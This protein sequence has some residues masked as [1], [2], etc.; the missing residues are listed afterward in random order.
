MGSQ[1]PVQAL[2]ADVALIQI[3]NQPLEQ[4]RITLMEIMTTVKLCKLNPKEKLKGKFLVGKEIGRAEGQG[5][6]VDG[7]D[8]VDGAEGEEVAEEE[9]EAA[10]EEEEEAG[11]EEEAEEVEELHEEQPEPNVHEWQRMNLRIYLEADLVRICLED[12]SVGH[13]ELKQGTR[14]GELFYIMMIQITTT[15]CTPRIL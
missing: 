10:A 6:E 5:G 4:I 8:G 2:K 9:E 13:H 14:A 12:D 11:E 15:L 3:L 7:A 1:D